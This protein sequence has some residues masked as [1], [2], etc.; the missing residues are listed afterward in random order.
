MASVLCYK[1][2]DEIAVHSWPPHRLHGVAYPSYAE[3]PYLGLGNVAKCLACSRLSCHHHVLARATVR[4]APCSWDM[5]PPP[6]SRMLETETMNADQG[7]RQAPADFVRP[8]AASHRRGDGRRAATH[9]R[10][11][12]RRSGDRGNSFAAP[13]PSDGP[14]DAGRRW[15]DGDPWIGRPDPP[16][17][18]TEPPAP[19]DDYPSWPGRPGPA[20]LHPDHPSWPGRPVPDWAATEAALRADDYPS[21]PEGKVPPWRDPEP[22]RAGNDAPGWSG[23]GGIR[24]TMGTTARIPRRPALAGRASGA[25]PVRAGAHGPRSP[26]RPRAARAGA[27]GTGDRGRLPA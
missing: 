5:P 19:E 7:F 10:T 9:A 2:L 26:R 24:R 25:G 20:A 15:P 18:G 6:F 8:T 21:W 23:G 16:R 13:S 22:P 27:A 3:L 4:P 17:P 1:A 14:A 11:S 12:R